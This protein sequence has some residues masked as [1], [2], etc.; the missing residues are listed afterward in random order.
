MFINVLEEVPFC[1]LFGSSTIGPTCFF[2]GDGVLLHN[3]NKE[4]TKIFRRSRGRCQ[5]LSLFAH[6]LVTLLRQSHSHLSSPNV[7]IPAGLVVRTV[8]LSE[9]LVLLFDPGFVCII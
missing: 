8:S 9:L 7:Y 2:L 5:I 4:L 3:S 6:G 1:R